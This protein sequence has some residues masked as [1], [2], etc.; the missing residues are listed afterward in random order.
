MRWMRNTVLMVVCIGLLIILFKSGEVS[1]TRVPGGPFAGLAVIAP[2]YPA[3]CSTNALIS[4]WNSSFNETYSSNN[5]N[6]VIANGGASVINGYCRN[7]AIYNVSGDDFLVYI[8]Q[9]YTSQNKSEQTYFVAV[10]LSNP[11][12]FPVNHIELISNLSA[13]VNGL[14][15]ISENRTI[16]PGNATDAEAIFSRLF[17]FDPQNLAY[18][19]NLDVYNYTDMVN[20]SYFLNTTKNIVGNKSDFSYSSYT[21]ANITPG[22]SPPSFIINFNGNIPNFNTS[23]DVTLNNAFDLDTYFQNTTSVTYTFSMNVSGNIAFSVGTG[24]NVTITPSSDWNGIISANVTAKNVSTINTTV[25]SNNFIVNVTPVNDPPKLFAN[26][27]NL[28]WSTLSKTINLDD[29][30]T[31]IEGQALTFFAPS[32]NN[33][34]IE[35]DDNDNDVVFIQDPGWTGSRSVTIYANDSTNLMTPSN[36]FTLTVNASS[37]GG[38]PPSQPPG[39]GNNGTS[40]NT[41]NNSAPV[42][43]S[44]TPSATSVT[45]TVGGS[46]TFSVGASDPN[47]NT[48]TYT[49]K[50]NGVTQNVNTNQYTFTPTGEGN[51]DIMVQISDGANIVTSSWGIVVNAAPGSGGSGTDQPSGSS[52]V[53]QK[54]KSSLTTAFIVLGVSLAVAIGGF[55]GFKYYSKKTGTVKTTFEVKS[56]GESA[57]KETEK[58][59]E[60]DFFEELRKEDTYYKDLRKVETNS[61]VR[62]IKKYKSEGASDDDIKYVLMKKGWKRDAV[63]DAFSKTE[64]KL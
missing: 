61:L 18:N 33:I 21:V 9:N 52:Q 39:G 11:I 10:N 29:F 34:D 64:K 19:L 42:I 5:L 49:W 14:G 47:N 35:F 23:E 4:F 7:F 3:S 41:G 32:V 30:F 53:I 57:E 8:T 24:N 28:A 20:A 45:I 6:L 40:N 38:N 46:M 15:A 26:I 1:Y 31:E 12:T 55:F 17:L 54:P 22:V 56:D 51:Y 27:P 36:Q 37:G 58:E 62:F 63:E 16:I 13:L 48:L 50:V 44:K 43:V 2:S 60:S 25:T 59:Q